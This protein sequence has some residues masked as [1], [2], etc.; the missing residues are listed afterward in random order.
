[1]VENGHWIRSLYP[2]MKKAWS[3]NIQRT[4]TRTLTPIQIISNRFVLHYLH[5]FHIEYCVAT[6]HSAV[7]V[8]IRAGAKSSD[9]ALYIKSLLSINAMLRRLSVAL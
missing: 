5:L 2:S 8:Q 9:F 7:Y 6:V 1:M 4:R 3:S